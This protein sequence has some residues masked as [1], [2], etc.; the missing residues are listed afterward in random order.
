MS[1]PYRKLPAVFLTSHGSSRNI[2]DHFLS[3]FADAYLAEMRD[4]VETMLSGRAP[5]V[6]GEDGLRALEIAVAA[7]KSHLQ[8]RPFKV[9]QEKAAH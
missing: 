4:F 3:Q 9:S 8:G 1:A 5:R 6:T 2:A 7:E